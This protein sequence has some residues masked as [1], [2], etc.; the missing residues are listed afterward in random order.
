M[1]ELYETDAGLWTFHQRLAVMGAEI[2]MRMTV[3]RLSDG[4]LLVHS[5]IRLTRD[6]EQVLASLG[7][8]E[9]V[10]APNLAPSTLSSPPNPREVDAVAVALVAGMRGGEQA[11]LHHHELVLEVRAL[12]AVR[13]HRERW[14][15]GPVRT[16][17]D[18]LVSARVRAVAV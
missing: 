7:R 15:R 10:L 4:A 12:V 5:P 18:Q 17:R 2:G 8:V 11:I 13:E 16:D 9:H 3:V 1:H 14:L 6:L